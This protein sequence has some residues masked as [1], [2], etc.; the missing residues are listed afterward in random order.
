M[1]TPHPRTIRENDEVY[2]PRCGKRWGVGDKT[3]DCLSRREYG[4]AQIAL[5]RNRF[6][7]S[8]RVL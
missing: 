1:M 2:C 8:K 5:L 3:P 4:K 7:L 6:R